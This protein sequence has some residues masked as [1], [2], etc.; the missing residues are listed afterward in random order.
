MSLKASIYIRCIQ[1]TNWINF[2]R[3]QLNRIIAEVNVK[4]SETKLKLK[5]K[6]F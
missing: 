3:L 6:Q 5:F 2:I 4:E 1:Y